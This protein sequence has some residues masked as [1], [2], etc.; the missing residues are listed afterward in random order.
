MASDGLAGD[1]LGYA[2]AVSGDLVVAGAPVDDVG[3]NGDQGSAYLFG[4]HQGGTNN[5]GQI[6]RLAATDGAAGDQ[7]GF[8]VAVS[9]DAVVA[10][11]VVDNGGRGS[12]YVFARQQGGTNNWGQVKRLFASDA[13]ANDWFGYSVAISGDVVL[14]GAPQDDSSRGSAY[15]FERNQGGTSFWGQRQKLTASDG[16]PPDNFG[17]SVS[18]STGVALAG[19]LFDDVGSNQDQGSASVFFLPVIRLLSP[20]WANGEFQV[21]LN[22]TPGLD[23]SLLMSSNLVDWVSVTNV[24][25][26]DSPLLISVPADSGQGLFRAVSPPVP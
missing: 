14:A 18:V 3:L 17:F 6:K 5:W 20:I 2:V 1:Q 15:L 8:S 19:A 10:G 21:T 23:C 7:L 25:L 16:V 26:P 12:A 22:G 13:A 24:T 4:R 11:A 9:G